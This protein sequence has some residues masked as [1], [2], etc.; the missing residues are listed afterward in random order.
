VGA[1]HGWA[2]R[3]DTDAAALPYSRGRTQRVQTLGSSQRDRDVPRW[4]RRVRGRG[5][6]GIE[7]RAG[8]FK[9][10]VL[11]GWLYRVVRRQ[12]YRASRLQSRWERL[13]QLV[14]RS[15]SSSSTGG[16]RLTWFGII[17][18]KGCLL[19]AVLPREYDDVIPDAKISTH[20]ELLLTVIAR[21]R[22]LRFLLFDGLPNRSATPPRGRLAFPTSPLAQAPSPSFNSDMV[23]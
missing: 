15:S 7:C 14:F 23:I 5:G 20:L 4:R 9:R 8:R 18:S 10:L 22:S 11:P 2:S 13:L 16:C 17:G 1:R 6:H 21:P 3:I 19:P 12:F